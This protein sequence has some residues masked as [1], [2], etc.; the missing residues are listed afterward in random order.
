M[1][2]LTRRAGETIRIGNQIRVIVREVRGRQVRIGVEAPDEVPIHREEI[3]LRIREENT[4]AADRS[5][6]DI[7]SLESFISAARPALASK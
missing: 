6:P 1:L 7:E 2:T 3:Y 4:G 5:A